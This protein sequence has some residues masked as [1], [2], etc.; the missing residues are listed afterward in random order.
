VPNENTQNIEIR[1]QIQKQ[2]WNKNLPYINK[3]VF[4]IVNSAVSTTLPAFAA[5]RRA[6][7]PRCCWAP[8]PA[9]VD[10]NVL[11][12]GC[13]AANPPHAGL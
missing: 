7:A 1:V 13:S 8:A 3:L 9:A 10:R 11:P 12:A 6:A 5:E 2:S 4:S